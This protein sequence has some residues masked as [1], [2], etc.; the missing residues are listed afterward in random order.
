MLPIKM[1]H[2]TKLILK[3]IPG[4]RLDNGI[5]F[6]HLKTIDDDELDEEILENFEE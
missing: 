1:L 4:K 3:K 5:P 6:K 2:K